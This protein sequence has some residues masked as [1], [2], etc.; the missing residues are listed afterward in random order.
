MPSGSHSTSGGSHS[1]GGS[2]FGGHGSS[3]SGSSGSSRPIMPRRV[4]FGHSYVIL[5]SGKQS[6]SS[7][8]IVFAIFA[9]LFCAMFGFGIAGTNKAIKKIK[10]DQAYYFNMIDYARENPEY[11]TTG[12]V[13]DYFYNE[14]AGKYYITYTF[15]LA[16]GNFMRPDGQSYCVY[17]LSQASDLL[18]AGTIELA[19]NVKKSVAN[20]DTDSIPTDYR[21][22]PLD[23]D[24]E[25]VHNKSNKKTFIIGVVVTAF[26]VVASVVGV[27][28]I[29]ATS[30][31]EGSAT[32]T[33]SQNTTM[34]NTQT[35]NHWVCA[36]CGNR[37]TNDKSKCDQ[38][39]AKRE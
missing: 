39:G 22:M 23:D 6:L 9:L 11:L 2:S 19:L 33:T 30:P 14:D 26:I 10:E 24:G 21:E 13:T 28:V 17:T 35:S 4:Y 7:F 1:S 37:Q 12:T 3:G 32:Q 18:H 15:E 38:C 8:L 5:S 20:L 29:V 16:D 31:K 27:V 34:Q 25:Y 36:Y